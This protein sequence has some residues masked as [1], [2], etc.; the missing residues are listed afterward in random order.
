MFSNVCNMRGHVISDDTNIRLENEV[1]RYANQVKSVSLMMIN[2]RILMR[3][4][5][6][7]SGW[8]LKCLYTSDIDKLKRQKSVFLTEQ[9][10]LPLPLWEYEWGTV[11]LHND[12]F[13]KH[14]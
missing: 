14:K 7:Q 11:N 9:N 13:F 4:A 8:P 2:F 3:L 1:Y 12:C 10:C 6:G 5:N